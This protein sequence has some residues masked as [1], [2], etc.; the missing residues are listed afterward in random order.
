MLNTYRAKLIAAATVAIVA[1]M[2]I[3]IVAKFTGTD[4][5]A[6]EQPDALPGWCWMLDNWRDAIDSG[7][8]DTAADWAVEMTLADVPGNINE[9]ADACGM[10][11]R[12]LRW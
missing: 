4:T 12:G 3:V 10:D 11:I 2:L 7:D 5:A 6:V 8:G 1:V 9:R